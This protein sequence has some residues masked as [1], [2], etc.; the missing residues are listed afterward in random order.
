MI[1]EKVDSVGTSGKIYLPADERKSARLKFGTFKSKLGEMQINS[2]TTALM[3]QVRKVEFRGKL[4]GLKGKAKTPR[5]PGDLCPIPFVM[6]DRFRHTYALKVLPS[7]TTEEVLVVLSQVFKPAVRYIIT[8]NSSQFTAEEFKEF[9][10][11]R[12]RSCLSGC[13]PIIST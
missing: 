6:D 8:D 4:E 3:L 7:V 9:C 10:E 13:T 2:L 1:V 5:E 12:R 11:G